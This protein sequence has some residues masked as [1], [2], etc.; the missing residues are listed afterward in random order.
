VE[1]LMNWGCLQACI[2]G[3]GIAVG[4]GLDDGFNADISACSKN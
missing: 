4:V 2:V 1:R 3:T